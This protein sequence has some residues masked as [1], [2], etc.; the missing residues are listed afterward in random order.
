M[1]MLTKITAV[2][3]LMVTVTSCG[4]WSAGQENAFKEQCEKAG[5]FDCDCS[6]K[7]VKEKYPNSSDFNAKGAADMELAEKL[8]ECSK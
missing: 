2:A 4:G 1:K 3:M 7:L 8:L 5:G 6:L